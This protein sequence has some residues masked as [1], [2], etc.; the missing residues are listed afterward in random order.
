MVQTRRF[1]L[2]DSYRTATFDVPAGSPSFLHAETSSVFSYDLRL[3][4]SHYDY[5]KHGDSALYFVGCVF[6]FEMW[7]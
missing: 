2:K 7:D 4:I 1:R 3:S 5:D 6:P